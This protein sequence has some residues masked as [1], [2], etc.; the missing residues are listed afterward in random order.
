VGALIRF[1]RERY[2]KLQ[3]AALLRN[4]SGLRIVPSR[5]GTVVFKGVLRFN[6]ASPSDENI[7][8]EYHVEMRVPA[9]FPDA[10]PMVRETGRRI[11]SSYHKLKHGYLCLGTPTQIRMTLR[12]SPTLPTFVDL[13]VI[14]YLFGHSFY[15]RHGKVP[16]G[17]LA[18]GAPGIRQHL[19]DL[20][21]V[22]SSKQPEK[23]LR[24]AGLKMRVANKHPCPCGSGRRLGQCHNRRVNQLRRT[25]GRTWFCA[26]YH[27]V[28]RLLQESE[29]T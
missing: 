22:T 11:P 27:R 3:V 4:H 18:H 9:G 5:N 6:F 7:S 1:V 29:D 15:E 21:N 16:Y 13:F 10:E 26:E 17:E 8:D 24:V 28:V 14:P 19:C 20:F 2:E 25:I 12:R 23:F